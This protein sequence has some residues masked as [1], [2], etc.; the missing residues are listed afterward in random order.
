ML[1]GRKIMPNPWQV[2]PVAG[3]KLSGYQG[4]FYVGNLVAQPKDK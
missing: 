4:K 2:P 1:A 3:S